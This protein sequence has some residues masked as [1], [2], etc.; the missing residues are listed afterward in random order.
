MCQQQRSKFIILFLLAIVF[1]SFTI[2]YPIPATRDISFDI[3]HIRNMKGNLV[4]CFFDSEQNY[5]DKKVYLRKEISKEN[6]KD[7]MLSC[8]LNLPEGYFGVVL[9]DDENLNDLMDYGGLLPLEGF[10]FSN[11]FA[12]LCKPLFDDFGF[13]IPSKTNTPITIKIKYM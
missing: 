4:L 1:Y 12:V 11:H 10:G 8:T 6:A 13:D 5:N 7:G 3:T 2:K 9:L